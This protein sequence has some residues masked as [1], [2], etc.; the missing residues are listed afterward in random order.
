MAIL[1]LSKILVLATAL[2]QVWGAA[3]DTSIAQRD[4]EVIEGDAFNTALLP[5]ADRGTSMA[6]QSIKA[7]GEYG[8][9][10]WYEEIDTSTAATATDDEVYL[11]A[12]VSWNDA[13]AKAK[14]SNNREA[15]IG[16]ALFIPSKGWILDTSLKEV[17][18]GKQSLQ[19][20]D[21]VTDFNHKNRANCAEMNA[22]A[23]L[24]QKGWS[25]PDAGAKMAC[26]GNYG[27]RGVAAK[28]VNP[29]VQGDDEML[30]CRNILRGKEPYNKIRVLRG[31]ND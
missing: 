1:S 29:C 8:G 12:K 21:V 20:C 11:A 26:Y 18:R 13:V 16:C 27:Q 25:V 22:L 19:T 10:Y 6:Y 17:G 3:I 23:I 24:Q 31:K 2:A 9:G 5:R 14:A 15:S 28:W 7:S 30:G 4:S